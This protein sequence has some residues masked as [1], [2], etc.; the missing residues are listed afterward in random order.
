MGI[1][2]LYI[3]VLVLNFKSPTWYKLLFKD[4][5]LYN[6]GLKTIEPCVG[7]VACLCGKWRTVLP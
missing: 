7:D 4:L 5:A 6:L 1:F 2:T 3:I